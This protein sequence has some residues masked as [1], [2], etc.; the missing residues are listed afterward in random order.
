MP[1]RAAVN[2]PGFAWRA[3]VNAPRTWPNSSLSMR[4][5]GSAAQLIGTKGPSR[6]ALSKCSAR[7]SRSL[8]VPLSPVNSTLAG[9]SATCL[10][11]SNTATIRGLVAMMLGNP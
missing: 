9:L 5:S 8:P 6:R 1:P 3:S 4:V 11:I 10:S 2:S 7:A